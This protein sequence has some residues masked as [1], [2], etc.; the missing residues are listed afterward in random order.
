MQILIK[1][2]K[3]NNSN[4]QYCAIILEKDVLFVFFMDKKKKTDFNG[5]STSTSEDVLSKRI[6]EHV[7]LV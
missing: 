5:I 2:L 4:A 3:C 6:V 7:E 1:I